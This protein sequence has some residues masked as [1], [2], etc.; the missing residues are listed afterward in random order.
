MNSVKT[1]KPQG[2]IYLSS[3]KLISHNKIL[4]H[5]YT[6]YLMQNILIRTGMIFVNIVDYLVQRFS[7][8]NQGKIEFDQIGRYRLEKS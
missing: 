8:L 3:S 5:N 6:K 2:K 7:K 1:Q 4:C